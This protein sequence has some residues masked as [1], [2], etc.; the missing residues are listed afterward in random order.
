M[1]TRK[2]KLVARGVVAT[3]R[4]M[5]HF[6][7]RSPNSRITL[8]TPFRTVSNGYIYVEVRPH[9]IRE[10]LEIWRPSDLSM[11]DRIVVYRLEPCMYHVTFEGMEG[12]NT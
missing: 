12:I 7:A 5:D 8:A 11:S 2:A 4:Y 10:M 9:Q 6:S 1:T 3:L